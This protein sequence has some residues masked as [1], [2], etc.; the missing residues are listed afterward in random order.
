LGSGGLIK[1][2]NGVMTLSRASYNTGG[3]TVNN[4]TLRLGAGLAANP[5]LVIPTATVPTVADLNVNGGTFDLNGNTQAFR[6]LTQF[7]T[8]SYTNGAGTVTN[9]STSAA[10]F[11]VVQDNTAATFSGRGAGQYGRHLLRRDLRR[12]HPFREARLQ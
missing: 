1:S 5:L 4:G 3:T 12:E 8:N 10:T 11:L 7:T 2:G 6:R 9:S